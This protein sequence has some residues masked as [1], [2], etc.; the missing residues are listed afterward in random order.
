[1]L[2]ALLPLSTVVLL[3]P[4]LHHRSR[5]PVEGRVRSLRCQT[6]AETPL[7]A[8]PKDVATQMSLAVSAALQAGST[9]MTVALPAGFRFGIFGEAGKQTIGKPGAAPSL[10]KAQRAEFELLF[11]CAEIFQGQCTCVLESSAAVKAAEREFSSK[12]L[13]PR[14]VP[15][16]SKARAKAA[17]EVGAENETLQQKLNET[18]QKLKDKHRFCLTARDRARKDPQNLKREA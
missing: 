8:N 9:S 4:G 5:L 16:V 15:S 7:P 2:L 18:T 11:L 13:R 1:M 14:L 3:V 10:A 12:G 17:R 6:A